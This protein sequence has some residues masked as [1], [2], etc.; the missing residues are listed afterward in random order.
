MAPEEA[1]RL[2]FADRDTLPPKGGYAVGAPAPKA[3]LRTRGP[4]M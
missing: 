2:G 3:L 4:L 1:S